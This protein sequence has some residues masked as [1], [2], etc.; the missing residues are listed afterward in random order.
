MVNEFILSFLQ[1]HLNIGYLIITIGIFC[2]AVFPI[3]LFWYGEFVFIPASILI[4]LWELRLWEVFLCSVTG[5][6][7]GDMVN[8]YLGYAYGR[9]LFKKN[10][11]FLNE[12]TLEKGEMFFKKYGMWGVFLSKF[13]P[14]IPWTVSFLAG[15]H[16]M[17]LIIFIIVD[18][19]ASVVIF[20]GIYV[21]LSGSTHFIGQL[22]N[23]IR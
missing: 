2:S 13:V 5:S 6:F 3:S 22:L 1:L 12:K 19:F 15:L 16:R 21:T 9:G 23:L 20:G 18:I 8:Y 11:R 10:N 7:L 17:N 4:G 14:L